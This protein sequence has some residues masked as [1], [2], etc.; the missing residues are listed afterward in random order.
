MSSNKIFDAYFDTRYKHIN[1]FSHEQ[2]ENAC[3]YFER[4]YGKFLPQDKDAKILDIGCGTGFFLYYLKKKGYKNYLGIDI[5]RSQ[6]EFCKANV[7]DKVQL[8]DAFEFLKEK[9]EEYSLIMASDL[10]E[11][12]PKNKVILFLEL[13]HKALE[14][15]GYLLLR[16]PNMGNFFSLYARYAD[17]THECGF[18]ESSLYQVLKTSGFNEV[19][20]FSP[21]PERVLSIKGLIRQW[22]CNLTHHTIRLLYRMQGFRPPKILSPTLIGV[23]KK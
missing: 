4:N 18:T 19:K 3:R 6:I 15:G 7:T 23:A 21:K 9:N 11:H 22:L 13:V 1:V 2:Y 8:I 20:V 12:I 5:S 16:C 14:K 10:I 17:F